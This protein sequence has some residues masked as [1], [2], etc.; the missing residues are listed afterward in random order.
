VGRSPCRFALPCACLSPCWV[1]WGGGV[2]L[3]CF[4]L[5][6]PAFHL[7]FSLFFLA[8]SSKIACNFITIVIK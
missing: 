3:L 4:P 6:T 7:V 2:G 1:R 5:H 8:F